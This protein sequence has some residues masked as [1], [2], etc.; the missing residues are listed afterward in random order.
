MQLNVCPFSGL[1]VD[2]CLPNSDL[3]V[4]LC[5]NISWS[6]SL[7]I[8]NNCR[9]DSYLF[10]FIFFSERLIFLLLSDLFVEIY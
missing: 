7:Y 8:F 3:L 6:F 5:L 9:V 2:S 1:L 4:D 10:I